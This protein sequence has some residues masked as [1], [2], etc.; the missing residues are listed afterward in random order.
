M[1]Y[2]IGQTLYT[3]WY[4]ADEQKVEQWQYIVRTIRKNRVYCIAH[5]PGVTWGK[6]SSKTGDY[7]W[8]DPVHQDFR[9]KLLQGIPSTELFTTKLKAACYALNKLDREDFSSNEDYNTAGR[10][11]YNVVNKSRPHNQKV[12]P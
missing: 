5:L 4:D 7:G 9:I 6:K 8:L 12:K 1:T 3:V 2:R 10:K 11:L